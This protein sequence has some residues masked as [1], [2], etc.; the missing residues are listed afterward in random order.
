MKHYDEQ[1]DSIHK[2]YDSEEK[3][4]RYERSTDLV[5]A[6]RS[7][8]EEN[9]DGK[10]K[11]QRKQKLTKKERKA[12]AKQQR[13]YEELLVKEGKI[14]PR[15]R[16]V[17]RNNFARIV[18]VCVAFVIGFFAAFGT[19]IGA[20][21]IGGSQTKLKDL[22]QIAGFDYNSIFTDYAAD[23]SALDLIVEI[24]NEYK[25]GKLN[26]LGNVGKYTSLADQ[27]LDPLCE[28]FSQMGMTVDKEA[29][30][31]VPFSNLGSYL[32]ENVIQA[33]AIAD[34]MNVSEDTTDALMRA[35]C[36]EE[37][38]AGLHKITV[39]EFTDKS[40]TLIKGVEIEALLKTDGNSDS[41]LRYLAYGS[42]DRYTVDEDGVI[43]MLNGYSKRTIGDLTQQDAD[44][45][46]GATI[47]DIVSLGDNPSSFL[48]AVKNWTVTDLS[49]Q[50]KIER[51]KIG[52]IIGNTGGSALMNALSD[53]RISDLSDQ[54]KV[55]TLRLC[56]VLE[57]GENSA[58]I[59]RSLQD[60]RL[61]EF[62][63]TLDTLPLSKMLDAE[64]LA[65]NKL[66]KNL[67]NSTLLS[68]ANDIEHI[69]VADVF[70]DGMY[71]Y[72]SMEKMV[73]AYNDIP[74]SDKTGASPIT[75]G[76]YFEV[77]KAY[78]TNKSI[79]EKLSELTPKTASVTLQA[80][81]EIRCEYYYGN[82]PVSLGYFLKESGEN[83]RE[84]DVQ[85]GTKKSGNTT[86]AYY[87]VPIRKTL[88][89]VYTWGEVDDSTNTV[90][91]LPEPPESILQDDFSYY[92]INGENRRVDLE[93]MLTG[94]EE[95]PDATVNSS[96]DIVIGD[97][98]FRV[99]KEETTYY[100]ELQAEAETRYYSPA[101]PTAEI[102]QNGLTAHYYLFE[103]GVKQTELDRCLDGS[104]Y[105][106]FGR[107]ERND[108]GEL[109]GI[110]DDTDTSILTINDK[111][112]GATYA[113]NSTPLWSHYLH[114]LISQNPY[115]ELK[116][117]FGEMHNLNELT[118]TDLILYVQ[119]VLIG[120]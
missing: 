28:Q 22:S 71:T 98:V 29:L 52:Q 36:F 82:T 92:Y 32:N 97:Q 118:V 111:I 93:K 89:P 105:L 88:T 14:A 115:A 24:A 68:L 83:V 40:N 51:L 34:M 55:N 17:P 95:Y 86:V 9:N 56:D 41:A 20:I 76:R 31:G 19:L 8:H 78:E 48:L 119:N 44:L 25:A 69:T 67:K 74:E 42:S 77:V 12:L 84:E 61:G 102:D 54:N 65:N 90:T 49:N 37:T 59:L 85:T 106:L 13:E 6:P 15:Y 53:W 103:N 66:L 39:K 96:G 70:D 100:V 47:G 114:G 7:P 30:K 3:Y 2:N 23:L 81:E 99:F 45:F 112:S 108:A 104:W 38:E 91:P 26:T 72:Y 107:E 80:D 50:N 57:I 16:Y 46:G 5:P 113:V 79:S 43:T 75:T 120:A 35:L 73:Q 109:I 60:T 27:L 116:I 101:D 63:A 94:Y 10:D 87:Y 58:Q 110:K 21:A 18:S 64:E 11:N 33:M 62:S 1:N 117:S 4:G